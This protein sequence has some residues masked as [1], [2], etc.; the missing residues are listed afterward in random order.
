MGSLLCSPPDCMCG[1][2][3]YTCDVNECVLTEIQSFAA[4]TCDS[5]ISI[6]NTNLRR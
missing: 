5:K 4:N 3:G 6:T 1:E 2:V